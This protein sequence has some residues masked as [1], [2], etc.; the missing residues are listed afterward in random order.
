MQVVPLERQQIW[1]VDTHRATIMRHTTL[2]QI[3]ILAERRIVQ[4]EERLEIVETTH[5][6]KVIAANIPLP[7]TGSRNG[8]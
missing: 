2:F 4:V 6:R 3:T 5:P 8:I 7:P 1:T